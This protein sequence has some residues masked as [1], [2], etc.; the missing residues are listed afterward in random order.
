MFARPDTVALQA[1]N[2]L[3]SLFNLVCHVAQKRRAVL[4]REHGKHL[5]EK[6]SN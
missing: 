5:G 4:W 2:D 3:L 1:S 6:I